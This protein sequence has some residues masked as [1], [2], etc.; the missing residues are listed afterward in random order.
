M[1]SVLRT[2]SQRRIVPYNSLAIKNDQTI[3]QLGII[4]ITASVTRQLMDQLI[5]PCF[6]AFLLSMTK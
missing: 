3:S 6:T 2:A 5:Q 1:P 4:A